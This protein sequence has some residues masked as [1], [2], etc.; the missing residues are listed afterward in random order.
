MTEILAA[1]EAIWII[2]KMVAVCGAAYVGWI[3]LDTYYK[4]KGK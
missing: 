4:K 2:F 1:F 3:G